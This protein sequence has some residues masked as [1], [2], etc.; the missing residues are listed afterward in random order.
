MS[1]KEFAALM[2]GVVLFGVVFMGWA[3]YVQNAHSYEPLPPEPHVIT[4]EEWTWDCVSSGGR[5]QTH[6]D[7]HGIVT[8]YECVGG[9]ENGSV[10]YLGGR[11]YTPFKTEAQNG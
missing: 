11:V 5:Y 3:L 1:P 10:F 6:H 7:K 2:F 8:M 9:T 4:L